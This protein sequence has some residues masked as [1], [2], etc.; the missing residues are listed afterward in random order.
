MKPIKTKDKL[1]KRQKDYLKKKFNIKS[2]KDLTPTILTNL[3]EAMKE[4]TDSRQQKKCKY[5]MWDVVVCVVISALCGKKDWEEI[6]DFVV[7]K[8]NFFNSFLKMTGGIP[9]AK[10]YERIMAIIDYKELEKIILSFFKTITKDIYREIEILNFDGRV[11]NGIKRKKTYKS[12]EISPLNM[13]NV[14]S[15]KH[16]LCISSEII[17]SKTNEI[18]TVRKLLNTLNIEGS[19]VTWDAL[20]TQKDNVKAARDGGADYVVPIKKNHEIFYNELVSFF[21]SKQEEFIIAG[22]NNT[23]YLKEREYK[24][25]MTITYEYFQTEE[26]QWFEDKNDW[27]D[28]KS[29]G[30]VK[31]TITKIVVNPKTKKETEQTETEKRYYISNLIINIKLFSQAIRKHWSVENKLHW[32]LDV[33]FRQDKNRTLN[34]NALANLE[35]INKFCLGILK[36]VQVY[37][38]ISLKRI[39]GKLSLN[40]EDN[41]LELLALLALADGREKD[42]I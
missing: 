11:N 30:M 4:L 37:Y 38:G 39:I 35:I 40:I 3:K 18:P 15:N 10:T 13:L 24:N 2:Y 16:Q 26:V 21:D 12:N 29:F 23:G 31:K 8:Y 1:D 28:L 27:K 7:E 32:H 36:R 33:T 41:F 19:I 42:E 34:K 9:S 17:D 22:K 5:K 14:Y 25:G 20:N 6:H